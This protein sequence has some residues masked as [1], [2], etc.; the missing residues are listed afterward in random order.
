MMIIQP[1]NV[2]RALLWQHNNAPRLTTL[3]QGK[4]AWYASE[5]DGF[6]ERWQADVFDLRTASAFG[7]QVW[8]IILGVPIGV[9]P[10]GPT[11]VTVK[12]W[13]FGTNNAN[14][15]N[16]NFLPNANGASGVQLSVYEARVLLQL[17]YLYLTCYPSVIKI[18][19]RLS[20]IAPFIVAF[21]SF[22]MSE[23]RY[24]FAQVMS[25]QFL[26]LCA[27]GGILPQPSVVGLG[28]SV[29]GRKIFGFGTLNENF[30][31]GNFKE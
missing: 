24:E 9:A 28:I 3:L 17:R 19:E 21:D 15:N 16:G 11:P 12:P 22:D 25:A 29:F 26:A 27:Q 31:N 2:L 7:L 6:W 5:A 8:G 4:Q 30:N 23:I 10:D 1:T 13:G 20:Q 14:F 18:N